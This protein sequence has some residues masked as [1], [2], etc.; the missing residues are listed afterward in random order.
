MY[1]H[2]KHP[3]HSHTHDE[4]NAHCEN[5]VHLAT[6]YLNNCGCVSV[7]LCVH[8]TFNCKYSSFLWKLY[9]AFGALNTLLMNPT[10]KGGLIC[11][12]KKKL[13]KGLPSSEN[14]RH[15]NNSSGKSIS[16]NNIP[17]IMLKMLKTSISWWWCIMRMH[18]HVSCFGCRNIFWLMTIL[19]FFCQR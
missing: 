9:K 4:Y 14:Q 15:T 19:G 3:S 16:Q 12:R 2:W 17:K 10:R 18:V 5:V 6:I 8:N 13:G 1:K 7:C 11:I